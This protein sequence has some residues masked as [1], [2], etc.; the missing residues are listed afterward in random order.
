[1]KNKTFAFTLSGTLASTLLSAAP[2]VSAAG[3]LPESKCNSADKK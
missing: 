1:M 2:A 3:K